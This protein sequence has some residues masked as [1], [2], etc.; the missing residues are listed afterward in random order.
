MIAH[1]CCDCLAKSNKYG[2]MIFSSAHSPAFFIVAYSGHDVLRN[3]FVP[4]KRTSLLSTLSQNS[5]PVNI[6]F[7]IINRYTTPHYHFFC[8]SIE[9]IL[10]SF[11]CLSGYFTHLPKSLYH[12]QELYFSSISI[13]SFLGENFPQLNLTLN[14]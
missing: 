2:R 3:S 9:G 8:S 12:D 5:N 4:F 13:L 7:F 6:F 1:F 10:Q 11:P 14:F